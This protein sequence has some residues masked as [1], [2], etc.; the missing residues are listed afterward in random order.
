VI[1]NGH[2]GDHAATRRFWLQSAERTPHQQLSLSNADGFEHSQASVARLN[3]D[4]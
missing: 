3:Q 2:D 4:G 1:Y